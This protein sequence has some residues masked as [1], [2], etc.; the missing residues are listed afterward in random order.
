MA[1]IEY[2]KYIK[3]YLL[4]LMLLGAPLL[5]AQPKPE[6]L[7]TSPLLLE[8]VSQAM[9][10]PGYWIS[11]HPSPD[12][13]IMNDKEIESFNASIRKRRGS[14][15]HLPSLAGNISGNTIRNGINQGL[16]LLKS[17]RL[18][19]EKGERVPSSF[20]NSIQANCN[21]KAIPGTI[22]I[23]YA[24]PL[25]FADQRIAPTE[26]QLNKKVLDYELDEL[27]NS[28]FDIGTPLLIYHNSADGKWAYGSSAIT[29]GWFRLSDLVFLDVQSWKDY[30]QTQD[31]VV[32]TAAQA[33]LWKDASRTNY[34]GAAR[35]G[36]RFPL[37]DEEEDR[38][39]ISL[40]VRDDEGQRLA[41]GYILKQ[42]AHPKYLPYTARNVYELAF[43]MLNMPYGWADTNGN[44]D[45]SSYLRQLFSCFGIILPRNSAEQEKSGK[46]AHSFTDKESANTRNETLIKKGKPALTLLRR[47]GHITLYLGSVDG[48]AY[49]IHNTWA[50][51]VK[52]TNSSNKIQVINRVVVSDVFIGN[53]SLQGPMIKHFT[54]IS[55]LEL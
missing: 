5:M 13:I 25:A 12:V 32:I 40:P 34:A 48:R 3:Y 44:T 23:R 33:D 7:Y 8:N 30:Q 6:T 39:I 37:L 20:W 52:D 19:D 43:R 31:F 26:V 42:D 49:I 38:Y 36:S 14:V 29:S 24:L 11:R 28:G 21:L 16:N 50:E 1:Y 9:L 54:S 55:L 2:M 53:K 18:Y 51:R 46:I 45:C 4:V 41:S 15:S 35:M 22:K 27:Q 47:P 10:R 17:M